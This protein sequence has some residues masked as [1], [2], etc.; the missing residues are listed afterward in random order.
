MSLARQLNQKFDSIIYR[1]REKQYR[2][3]PEWASHRH[4]KKIPETNWSVLHRVI[5]DECRRR[6]IPFEE[7]RIDADDFSQFARKFR[8]SPFSLYALRSR[9]KKVMEHYVA[10][11]LL[12]LKPGNRYID[13]A[14][15]SSP[16]SGLARRK[17]G[18]EVYS[19]D[20]S[21]PKGLRG[22]RIGSS[23]D[24]LPVSDNW[25]DGASLQCAF[26]HFQGDIDSNFIRELARVLKQGGRCV[27]VPLYVGQKALNIYDPLLYADWKDA[28]ADTDAEIIAELAL[29]GHFERIYAPASLA[30]IL[31]PGLGLR[32]CVYYVT[33]KEDAF[34][35]ITAGAREQLSRIRYVLLIEKT[36][37]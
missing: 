21:Y 17:M 33:G 1:F 9:E 20:L 22:N 34:P 28:N 36:G 18:L 15:E 5:A 4:N 32:Y 27:I 26:E 16:F 2:H 14:S 29:G 30:R 12:D 19:Q 24:S 11:K 35:E 13:I 23:A 7:L 10:F 25:I 31:I 8:I 6:D 37:N 3:S